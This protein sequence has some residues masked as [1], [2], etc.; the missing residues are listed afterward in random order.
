MRVS[1]YK[2]SGIPLSYTKVG[3]MITTMDRTIYSFNHL[4]FKILYILVMGLIEKPVL[5]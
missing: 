3:E 4:D 5:L 2:K 1:N